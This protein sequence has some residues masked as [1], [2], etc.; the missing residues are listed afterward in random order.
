MPCFK[1]HYHLSKKSRQAHTRKTFPLQETDN[2]PAACGISKKGIHCHFNKYYKEKTSAEIRVNMTNANPSS[3]EIR[4]EA[5]YGPDKI[6]LTMQFPDKSSDPSREAAL[7]RDILAILDKE[8]LQLLLTEK[9]ETKLTQRQNGG[10][11]VL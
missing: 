6:L 7:R 9:S 8:L 3:K 11:D 1:C 10:K 5:S 2:R 4:R